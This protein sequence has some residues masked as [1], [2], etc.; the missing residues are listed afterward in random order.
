[1]VFFEDFS[2]YHL[3]LSQLSNLKAYYM[4]REVFHMTFFFQKQM[5]SQL[6]NVGGTYPFKLEVLTI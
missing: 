1:M 4:L 2:T 3:E 6:L 5:I